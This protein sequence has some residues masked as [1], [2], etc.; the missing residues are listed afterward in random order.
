MKR[1]T[2]PM[3]GFKSFVAAQA[4]LG[5]QA[6][7]VPFTNQTRLTFDVVLPLW[8]PR[9]PRPTPP[10]A[11]AQRSPLCSREAPS[12]TDDQH[13]H[14]REAYGVRGASTSRGESLGEGAM[15]R[16]EGTSM[17]GHPRLVTGPT[18][19]AAAQSSASWV[20]A[21]DAREESGGGLLKRGALEARVSTDQHER[22][23]PVASPGD[24]LQQAAEA[25]D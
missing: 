20:T 1:I 16:W 7:V 12:M 22:E 24:L 14:R 11:R 18:A 15:A 9:G 23:E 3:L 19:P 10:R 5:L 2:R 21:R 17:A 25:H 6:Q 8:G 13:T 4:T